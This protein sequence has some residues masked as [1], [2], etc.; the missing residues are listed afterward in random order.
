MLSP[1]FVC[2]LVSCTSVNEGLNLLYCNTIAKGKTRSKVGIKAK[3]VPNDKPTMWLNLHSG[4][5]DDGFKKHLVVHEFGHALGLGHEHQ[6][7]DFWRLLEPYLNK[8]EMKKRLG[9][10]GDDFEHDWG[11]CKKFAKAKATAY[12]SD[13]VMHYWYV[14]VSIIFDA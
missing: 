4:G 13:S 14:T 10:D 12:D 7:S 3:R 8:V 1:T 9:V 6:R 5:I 11:G 2:G